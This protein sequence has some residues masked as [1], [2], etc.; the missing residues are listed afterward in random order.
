M[1]PLASRIVV[2]S[3]LCL[4][5]AAVGVASQPQAPKPPASEPPS[6][7]PDAAKAKAKTPGDPYALD[8]CPISGGKLGSM[9]DAVVKTYDGREV[10]F[11]C[12]SCPPKFEKDQAKSM[13]KLDETMIKDQLPHYPVENSIVTGKK[14]PAK[15]IDWIYNNRLVRLGDE[16]E[17]AEFL[18]DPSKHMAMLDKVTIERQTKDYPL[19]ACVVSQEK[20]GSMGAPKDL[21]IAGRL[22]RLCCASCE[23]DVLK[24]PAKMVALVDAG[25]KGE[26]SKSDGQAKDKS[27]KKPDSPK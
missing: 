1:K 6:K 10:R 2:A 13:G 20:L 5:G 12:A 7:A 14:L 8:T 18:K 23:K 15:P 17:K 22:I 19:K 9:G 11:C 25:R 4:T 26:K 24:D 16:S 21:V 27:D 3:L